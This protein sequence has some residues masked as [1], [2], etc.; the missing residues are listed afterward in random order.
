MQNVFAAVMKHKT[1]SAWL[2]ELPVADEWD[3]LSKDGQTED[4]ELS[5]IVNL[6]FLFLTAQTDLLNSFAGR[7]VTANVY[8][9]PDSLK[10]TPVLQLHPAIS[11]IVKATAGG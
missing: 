3:T 5:L 7:T 10:G 8:P 1:V 4:A 9:Y 2:R 6:C 11:S